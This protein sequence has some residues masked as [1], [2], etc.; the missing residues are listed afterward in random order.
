MTSLIIFYFYCLL[1]PL[2]F[3]RLYSII[4]NVLS[5][6]P[7][8]CSEKFWDARWTF[9]RLTNQRV[10]RAPTR[11]PTPSTLI[12]QN[13]W[14]LT[15]HYHYLRLPG[16]IQNQ[17]QAICVEDESSLS[18]ISLT[19]EFAT[20]LFSDASSYIR[21]INLGLKNYE[22]KFEIFSIRKPK[23][24]LSKVDCIDLLGHH[25]FHS[26]YPVSC[27]MLI[28]FLATN[29]ISNPILIPKI[30]ESHKLYTMNSAWKI[31]SV[32]YIYAYV[33]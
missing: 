17:I 32:I 27:L 24:W 18:T 9:L 21:Y 29:L 13:N 33:I 12:K 28:F 8:V 10:I 25:I 2:N 6:S 5:W 11:S 1:C 23:R 4:I 30:M 14:T 3:Y 22:A 20:E 15:F 26:I 31:R 16:I 19:K 7:L